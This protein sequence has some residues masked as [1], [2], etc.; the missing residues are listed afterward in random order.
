[1]GL[2]DEWIPL[3]GVSKVGHSG[4]DIFERLKGN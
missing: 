1:M 3:F 4:E 2:Y